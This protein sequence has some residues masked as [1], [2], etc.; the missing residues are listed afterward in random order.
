MIH[1]FYCS[2]VHSQVISVS[3]PVFVFMLVEPPRIITQP[4][5]IKNAVRGNPGTFIIQVYGAEPLGYQW[6]WKSAGKG[7]GSRKW[8]L[9]PP[10]WYNRSRLTIPSVEKCNEGSYRCVVSNCAGGQTS[11]LAKLIVGKNPTVNVYS[12]NCPSY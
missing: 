7:C 8:Q 9:C 5:G 10:K 1:S 11:N 12:D 6:E 4:Q 2:V 3:H